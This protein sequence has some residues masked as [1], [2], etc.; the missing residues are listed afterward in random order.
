MPSEDSDQP[1]HR[2]SLI[3][4]FVVR[5]ISEYYVLQSVSKPAWM[6]GYY[7]L[8]HVCT[9]PSLHNGRTFCCCRSPGARS[10]DTVLLRI[11]DSW[12][13]R[14]R[15]TFDKYP[16]TPPPQTLSCLA[17]ANVI[18]KSRGTFFGNDIHNRALLSW[19]SLFFGNGQLFSMHR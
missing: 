17:A 5:S 1:G 4:V 13:L 7:I 15:E 11:L 12:P 18:F 16:P 2:P 10:G 3:R 8:V 9:D 6:K 19:G 14:N